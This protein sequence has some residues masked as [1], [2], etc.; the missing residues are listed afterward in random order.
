VA[1]AYDRAAETVPAALP[2]AD[3]I[4]RLARGDAVD[5]PVVEAVRRTGVRGTDTVPVVDAASG[6]FLG[7]VRRAHV[8]GL[9]ERHLA[10]GAARPAAARSHAA[11]AESRIP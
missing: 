6:R 9:Y 1:D 4:A 11:P 5:L 3:L 8:L 7:L 2:V 10:G